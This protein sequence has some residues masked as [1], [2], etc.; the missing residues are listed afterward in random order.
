[1][2]TVYEQYL[3]ALCRKHKTLR[4]GAE[5]RRA[6]VPFGSEN[7]ATEKGKMQEYYMVHKDFS[8]DSIDEYTA[9]CLSTLQVLT[10]IPPQ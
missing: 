4:H 6:W 1:M 5:G 7:P 8:V 3:E 9:R 10:T 2:I